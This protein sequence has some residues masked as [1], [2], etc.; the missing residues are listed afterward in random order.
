MPRPFDLFIVLKCI[1][2]TFRSLDEY[3]SV[4][5]LHCFQPAGHILHKKNHGKLVLALRDAGLKGV[6]WCTIRELFHVV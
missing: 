6:L 3:S 1:F 2:R 4:G 5:Q